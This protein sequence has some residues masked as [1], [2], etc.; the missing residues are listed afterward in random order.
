[1]IGASIIV[2]VFTLADR[3]LRKPV[4]SEAPTNRPPA[5]Q[6]DGEK[7]MHHVRPSAPIQEA[8]AR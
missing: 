1:M 4:G 3:S 2:L 5:A 7:A 6:R 8:E